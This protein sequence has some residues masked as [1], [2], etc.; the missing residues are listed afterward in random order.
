MTTHR[1]RIVEQFT[2]QAVP[3]S[4]APLISD[5]AL[6]QLLVEA[7]G[8]G[9]D[10]MVLDVACGPGLVACAF[11]RSARHVTGIDV[12]PAMIARAQ[13]VA[14]EQHVSNVDFRLGDVS[15]LPFPDATFSVVVSRFAFHHFPD[16]GAVL[17]EMRRVCRPGG[18][19][20][21]AD[22]T[23]SSEPAKAETFHRMEILRDPSHARALS[24]EELRALFEAQRLSPWH[25]TPFRMDVDLEGVLQ[26]SFP[27]PGDEEVIR[28]MFE[29]S[30]PD[31]SM[32]LEVRRHK[33]RLWFTYRNVIL[34]AVRPRE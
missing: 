10:D 27:K 7:S 22:L 17:G 24:L 34:V 18:R 21:V 3:F 15:P 4:T 25:E 26:R 16:P 31:D 13:A 20:V 30:L 28:R 33:R 1:E 8:A 11:A 9:P 23:V 29:D 12:T 14:A 32:G 19:V 5:Q 2:Q 6:L